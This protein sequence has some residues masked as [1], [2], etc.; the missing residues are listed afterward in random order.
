M[1]FSSR[2]DK[3]RQ[4]L[5]DV[6][7]DALILINPQDIRYLSGFSG[8]AGL[9]LLG[10]EKAYLFVDSRYVTQASQE[11]TGFEVIQV[12]SSAWDSL[13]HWA[14]E[15]KFSRMGFVASELAYEH[16]E[17]LKEKM[18]GAE[19]VAVRSLVGRLR[20]VKDPEEAE[21]IRTSARLLS[22]NLEEVLSLLQPGM[23]EKEI[24]ALFEYSLKMNGA[25]RTGFETIVASGFR[26]AMPHAQASDRAIQ[27]GELLKID[28]GCEWQGYHSDI[29][30]TLALGRATPD[31]E[32]IHRIVLEA[33]G[34]AVAA[35]RPGMIAGELDG[36]AR[37]VIEEGGYGEYFGHGTGHGVGLSVHEEPRIG[38][39]SKDLLEEGMAFTIEPGIY[40]PGL[41]G[42]RIEDTILLSA[43]GAEVV[44]TTPRGITL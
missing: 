27:A 33:H 35:A 25:D 9:A 37:R 22:Q 42:V 8:S 13:I 19:L 20:M 31:Q 41:G 11:I 18:E 3:A 44:T 1:R 16:H 15:G 21:A 28:G 38:R 39:D 23:K 36:V 24:A 10:I 4:S 7:L 6:A 26:S 2:L 40:V 14:K 32:K 30:R 17:K 5:E 29:T 12:T 43:R 34:Q